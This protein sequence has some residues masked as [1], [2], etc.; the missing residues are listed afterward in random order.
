MVHLEA[1][2]ATHW[3]DT[4]ARLIRIARAGTLYPDALAVLQLVEFAV[5]VAPKKTVPE[6]SL[7]EVTGLPTAAA[8]EKLL[9]LRTVAADYLRAHKAGKPQRGEGWSVSLAASQLPPLV[10]TTARLVSKGKD[11]RRFLV[12]HDRWEGR[13]GCPTRFTFHLTDTGSKHLAL[14]RADQATVT[15]AFAAELEV[16]CTENAEAAYLHLGL[17]PGVAIGEVV[18]G[19]LGPIEAPRTLRGPQTPLTAFLEAQGAAVFHLVLERAAADVAADVSRDPF[20]PSDT[21]PAT[22]ERRGARGYRVSRERRL[23]CLPDDHDALTSHLRSLGAS[24]LVRSR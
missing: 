16:A 8:L 18:M 1:D 23:C 4:A 17:L 12:V 14:D 13:T 6:V 7:N 15:K 19:Q 22:L 5:R 3:A 21:S 9:A 20:V 10:A 24:L 11:G 2:A